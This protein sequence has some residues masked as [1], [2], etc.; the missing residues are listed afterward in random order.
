VKT[1]R[2]PRQ[3]GLPIIL[4]VGDLEILFLTG[5]QAAQVLREGGQGVFGSHMQHH[6]VLFD[7]RLGSGKAFK[8]DHCVVA[9]LNGAGIDVAVV[10]FLVTDFFDAFGD[11]V[12]RDLRILVGH[13]KILVVLQFDIGKNFEFGLEA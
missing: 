4:G 13:L 7:R 12:V 5:R 10:S 11:V 6:L 3:F 8:R 1:N 2:A 9:I